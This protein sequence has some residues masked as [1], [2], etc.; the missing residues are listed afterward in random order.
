MPPSNIWP[1]ATTLVDLK[2]EARCHAAR[3][4][5]WIWQRL[6]GAHDAISVSSDGVVGLGP[7]SRWRPPP[8]IRRSSK[9]IPSF[10]KACSS[11]P[12]RNFGIWRRL[13]A[14][15]FQR[16][17]C[18]YFRDTSW[19]AC[20]KRDPGSGC[21]AMDGSNRQHAI[22][23]GSP[24]CIAAYPGDFAQSLIALDAT[25]S[26]AGSS[27]VRAISVR[28]SLPSIAG[29]GATPNAE[30]TFSRQGRSH[31]RLQCSSGPV[32]AALTVSQGP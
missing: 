11:P 1:E 8:T 26:V 6:P 20:N 7:W 10:P 25:V 31:H 2:S 27:G 12:V 14:M 4:S 15:C 13:A 23:G 30:T 29:R 19:T 32:D 18:P 5:E 28:Y 3:Q 16:I 17:R 24:D 22:L 9:A 21:A